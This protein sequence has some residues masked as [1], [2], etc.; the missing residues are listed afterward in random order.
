MSGKVTIESPKI[1]RTYLVTIYPSPNPA[2]GPRH[3]HAPKTQLPAK[4]TSKPPPVRPS[5]RTGHQHLGGRVMSPA[6]IPTAPA[7]L[8]GGT[9]RH[10]NPL[11]VDRLHHDPQVTNGQSRHHP[12]IPMDG[13]SRPTSCLQRNNKVDILPKSRRPGLAR[14]TPM[15]PKAKPIRPT[16]ALDGRAK[17]PISARRPNQVP[18]K[19]LYPCHWQLDQVD[20]LKPHGN[21]T[22]SPLAQAPG[23]RVSH[24]H[25]NFQAASSSCHHL[26]PS[27]WQPD[28]VHPT[29]PSP[30]QTGLVAHSKFLVTGQ[31]RPYTFPR[32]PGQVTPTFHKTGVRQNR[33][34]PHGGLAKT[35]PLTTSPGALASPQARCRYQS[36]H[37]N[38]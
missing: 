32:W 29:S 34:K 18:S 22:K 36:Q 21:W 23:G 13:L 27:P 24:L 31:S 33:P 38:Y 16:P 19:P 37:L 17:S 9:V 8:E 4:S 6:S 11:L 25:P 28:K 5:C 2:G 12:P 3:N 7:T 20:P 15:L 35:R 1:R 14:S 10:T 26:H 30:Q